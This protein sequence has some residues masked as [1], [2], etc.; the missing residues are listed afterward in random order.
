[1]LKLD[2]IQGSEQEPEKYKGLGEGSFLSTRNHHNSKRTNN[3]A[4]KGKRAKGRYLSRH[5]LSGSATQ[6]V[7]TIQ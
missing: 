3:E 2:G 6:S 1:M 5:L 4:V 7:K